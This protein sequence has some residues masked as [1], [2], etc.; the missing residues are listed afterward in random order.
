M[1][2]PVASGGHRRKPAIVAWYCNSL[3]IFLY[4]ADSR[5][6]SIGT[7]DYDRSRL[8]RGPHKNNLFIVEMTPPNGRLRLIP[9]LRNKADADAWIVQTARMLH[10]LY[11][12]HKVVPR[13]HGER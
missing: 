8:P 10:G 1:H 9:D 7:L 3:D 13:G 4:V 2:P 5:S 6:A 12:T 11:P